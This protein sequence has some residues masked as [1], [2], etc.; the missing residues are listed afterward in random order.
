MLQS[1]ALRLGSS[2][3]FFLNLFHSQAVD[4]SSNLLCGFAVGTVLLHPIDTGQVQMPPACSSTQIWRLLPPTLISRHLEI[5]RGKTET[6]S[7]VEE[8]LLRNLAE[9]YPV[10]SFI[11]L[12]AL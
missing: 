10:P 11:S 2:N 6:Q 3:Q 4:I 7:F 5:Q 1:Y 12:I 9:S 8:N